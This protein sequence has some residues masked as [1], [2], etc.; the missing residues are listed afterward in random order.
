MAV[1]AE[2]LARQAWQRILHHPDIA[3]ALDCAGGLPWRVEAADGPRTDQSRA[4]RSIEGDRRAAT[5]GREMAHGGVGTDINLGAR[6]QRREL[7]PVEP[8]IEPVHRRLGV[9][10]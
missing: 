7:R 5:A 1:A 4:G 6:E 2:L 8:A 3:A 9:V 10:P